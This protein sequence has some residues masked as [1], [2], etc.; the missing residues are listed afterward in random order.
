ME[1]GGDG[2][3]VEADDVRGL[4]AD[5]V[6]VGSGAAVELRALGDRVYEN[7]KRDHDVFPKQEGDGRSGWTL[8]D[9]GGV[10][11]HIF[12]EE[13]RRYYDLE[14]FW[15]DAKVLLRIQ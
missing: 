4:E 10:V 1:E 6:E 15:K 8:L 14:G 12:A 2:G 9:Y 5:H 3:V 7:I 11:V 13:L